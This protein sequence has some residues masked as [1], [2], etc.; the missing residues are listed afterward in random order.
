M[1]TKVKRLVEKYDDL[2]SELE[3]TYTEDQQFLQDANKGDK[4][5]E[6]EVEKRM[7]LAK[8]NKRRLDFAKAER[9][10]LLSYH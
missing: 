6:Q 7:L 8:N 5:S 10:L 9:D 3:L 4:Y 2:I 1:E